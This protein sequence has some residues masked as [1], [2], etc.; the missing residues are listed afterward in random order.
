MRI[1]TT[2]IEEQKEMVE[3]HQ[4]VQLLFLL[5]LVTSYIV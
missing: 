1:S 2:F 4:L 3:I 5:S